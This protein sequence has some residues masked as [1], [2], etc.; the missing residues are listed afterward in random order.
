[1]REF[2][3]PADIIDAVRKAGV[4]EAKLDLPYWKGKDDDDNIYL[5]M[6]D[7]ANFLKTDKTLRSLDLS[8]SCFFD[9]CATTLASAL[10]C[11]ST[12]TH[13]NL[14]DHRLTERGFA[15]LEQALMVNTTLQSISLEKFYND[16]SPA[17]LEAK[18]RIYYLVA[19]NKEAKLGARAAVITKV[20]EH[21]DIYLPLEIAENIA[22]F[23]TDNI[24]PDAIIC[25]SAAEKSPKWIK[26]A[27]AKKSNFKEALSSPRTD[28]AMDI[29]F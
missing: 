8:N 17:E 23:P 2:K 3:W 1:M 22:S 18:Q 24:V 13:L 12:L 6:T 19:C 20:A 11:N 9:N 5:H 16:F 10:N 29:S 21:Y 26:E 14:G 28:E 15:A 4:K 7:I 25:K 27:L